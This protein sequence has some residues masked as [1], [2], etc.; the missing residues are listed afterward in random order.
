MTTSPCIDLEAA[1]PL[2]WLKEIGPHGQ[3]RRHLAVRN[4]Q[5]RSSLLGRDSPL[6]DN[7][8]FFARFSGTST[9]LR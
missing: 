7:V 3:W 9:L 8:F 4:R 1:N 5:P 2:E 6:R